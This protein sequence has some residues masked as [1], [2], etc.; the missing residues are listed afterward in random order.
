MANMSWQMRTTGDNPPRLAIAMLEDGRHI[1]H[2]TM[3][4]DE[5]EKLIFQIATI[6]ATM[7]PAVPQEL[8]SGKLPA[9]LHNPRIGIAD[10]PVLPGK[11]LAIRHDGIGW[12]SF[13]F[14]DEEAAKLASGLLDRSKRAPSLP[15][16]SQ[17]RN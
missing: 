15:N 11:A 8:D 4:A 1:G 5:A 14:G 16:P 13:F 12:L 7:N 10:L 9:G 17:A 2:V 6:R 3:S